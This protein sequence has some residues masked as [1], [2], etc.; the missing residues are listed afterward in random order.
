MIFPKYTPIFFL[1][2][3]Q[4]PEVEVA[5]TESEKDVPREPT[6]EPEVKLEP[7][8]EPEP[9]V[10]PNVEPESPKEPKQAMKPKFGVGGPRPIGFGENMMQQ[11]KL[12]KRFSQSVSVSAHR[13]ETSAILQCLPMIFPLEMS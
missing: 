1:L 10:E 7:P 13:R 8:S 4:L 2:R 12:T 3:H 11:L 9:K 5:S 6:P